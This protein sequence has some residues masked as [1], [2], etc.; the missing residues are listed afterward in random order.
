MKKPKHKWEITHLCTTR[1]KLRPTPTEAAQLLIADLLVLIYRFVHFV[2][3]FCFKQRS[4]WTGA[5]GRV[6]AIW[7][8]LSARS[9]SG[10]QQTG[11]TSSPSRFWY[12]TH[13]SHE[14]FIWFVD[15]MDII[16]FSSLFFFV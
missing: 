4:F 2:Y 10:S 14:I 13:A 11:F 6:K 9:K 7:G 3:D 8:D 12:K 15:L 1:R 5:A 16:D